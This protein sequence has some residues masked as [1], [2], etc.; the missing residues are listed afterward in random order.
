[1]MD[2]ITKDEVL[3]DI[4]QHIALNKVVRLEELALRH[5]VYRNTNIPPIQTLLAELVIRYQIIEE[6][7]RAANGPVQFIY[8]SSSTRRAHLLQEEMAERVQYRPKD[9]D[10]LSADHQWEWD[11]ALGILDYTGTP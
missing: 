11:K 5:R 3:R 8:L 10:Q 9:F 4:V 6:K 1:M 7:F 2:P